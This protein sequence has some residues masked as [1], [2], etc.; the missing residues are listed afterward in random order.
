MVN[1]LANTCHEQ[2]KQSLLL[3]NMQKKK[4]L[5]KYS[6]L[7]KLGLEMSGDNGLLTNRT[8]KCVSA[9]ANAF[10]AHCISTDA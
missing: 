9:C 1:P 3:K 2:F 4:L 5:K 7:Y 8:L 10:I 6:R